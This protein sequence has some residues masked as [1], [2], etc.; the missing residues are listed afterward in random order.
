MLWHREW[1]WG[2]PD[3]H[4]QSRT[5]GNSCEQPI[6]LCSDW[7]SGNTDSL[8]VS[9]KRILE[10]SPRCVYWA[11]PSAVKGSALPASGLGDMERP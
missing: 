3:Q 8:A 9:G 5:A 4:S 11:L 6:V 10:N 7:E 2:A 1:D